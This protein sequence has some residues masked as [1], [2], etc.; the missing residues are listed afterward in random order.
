[1][2]TCPCPR[3]QRPSLAPTGAF[4]AC[5]VCGYAITQTALHIELQAL[6]AQ[7]KQLPRRSPAR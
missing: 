7:D 6:Q 1:M 2:K 4:W 5:G 3:C